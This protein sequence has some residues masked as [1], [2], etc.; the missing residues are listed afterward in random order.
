MSDD[1]SNPWASRD[2]DA[3]APDSEVELTRQ[4]SPYDL[5][6]YDA[7]AYD[8][9]AQSAG[10]SGWGPYG[11]PAEPPAQPTAA[12]GWTPQA[13]PAEP[14]AASLAPMPSVPAQPYGATSD[15]APAFGAYGTQQFPVQQ[16]QAYPSSAQS[17]PYAAP[18]ATRGPV[19]PK[20]GGLGQLLDLSFTRYATPGLVKIVYVLAVVGAVVGWLGWTLSWLA[21]NPLL[22]FLV[23]LLGTIP[24]LL[25]I[26]FTRFLLEF[27]LATIRSA[28]KTEEIAARL[29]AL[30]PP[31][32]DKPAS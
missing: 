26:A 27:F 31:G 5:S 25:S 29:A 30:E 15:A 11:Q 9:P 23:L 7:A 19:A 18:S 4:R 20:E 14:P 2:G 8:P 21:M 16:P 24:A 13:Q 32:D 6:G 3:P 28:A 12:S 22:G 1:R 10:A 17:A